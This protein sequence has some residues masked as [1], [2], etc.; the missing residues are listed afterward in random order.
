MGSKCVQNIAM[1]HSE[2]FPNHFNKLFLI[3]ST[4]TNHVRNCD[5]KVRYSGTRVER[6]WTVSQM[7]RRLFAG[8]ET[9]V[10]LTDALARRWRG[11]F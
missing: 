7:E 11:Y 1:F 5:S 6:Y 10:P 9:L 8:V 4:G 3:L 2:M